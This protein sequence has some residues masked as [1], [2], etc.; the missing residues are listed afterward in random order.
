M[1]E[2]RKS[3]TIHV[4]EDSMALE[5]MELTDRIIAAAIEV[6]KRLG[7]GFLESIY[8]N[9]LV[10]E[11]RKRGL[12]VE[13]QVEITVQYDGALVGTHRLD[14]L[15]EGRVIVELK[16][17]KNLEDAHFCTVRSYLKALGKHHGL[18][19]NFSKAT[20]EIKRVICK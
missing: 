14:L 17:V 12:L 10:L 20:L 6:H 13:Q 15:V 9:A 8:E 16:T 19:L 5:L 1:Q 11:M 18:L 2:I 3:G 7:P 4:P